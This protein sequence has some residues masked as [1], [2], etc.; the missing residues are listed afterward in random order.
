MKLAAV[1]AAFLSAAFL[2]SIAGAV[3]LSLAYTANSSGKLYECGCPGDPYGGLAERVALVKKIRAKE[4]PLLLLD[5]G[6]MV[7]LFG[8]FE[9]RAG[10]VMNLMNLMGYAAAGVG[11]QELFHNTGKA[12]AMSGKAKFP[13][14]SATIARASDRK[15]AFQRYALVKSGKATVGITAVSDSAG[16]FIPEVNRAFDYVVLPWERELKSVLNELKGKADFIVVLSQMDRPDNEKLLKSF[17]GVDVVIQ[18]YGNREFKQPVRISNGYLV[19]P[20]D[21]GQF[22]GVMRLEKTDGGKLLLKKSELTPVLD[23]PQDGKAMDVIREY[24]RKRK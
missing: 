9:A 13:F 21:R 10:C 19:M 22:V 3:E 6:N 20:G 1:A 2:A 11:R 4:E 17:P 7:S 24:L 14:L 23:I 5:A 8:D 15:P 18:S 16:S 12:L